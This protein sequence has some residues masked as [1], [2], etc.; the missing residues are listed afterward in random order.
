MTHSKQK[1]EYSDNYPKSPMIIIMLI[2]NYTT[3]NQS[4]IPNTISCTRILNLRR[5]GKVVMK[6]I[7]ANNLRNKATKTSQVAIQKVFLVLM[8]QLITIKVNI[9]K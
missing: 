9:K 5:I 2:A 6:I 4:I 1:I 8:T 7:A 3:V